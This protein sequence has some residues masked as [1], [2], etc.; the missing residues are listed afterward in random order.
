MSGRGTQM[1]MCRRRCTCVTEDAHVSPKR[2]PHAVTLLM[3]RLQSHVSCLAQPVPHAGSCSRV[4]WM[5]G[6]G[7][8]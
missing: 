8:V 4:S 3:S 2:V 1:H 7:G 6:E 5:E